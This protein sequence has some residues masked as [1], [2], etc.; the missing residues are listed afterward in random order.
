MRS[1]R[2]LAMALAIVVVATP[3]FA[4]RARG[5][6]GGGGRSGAVG[7]AVPRGS[8]RSAAGPSRGPYRDYGYR[9]SRGYRGYGPVVRYNSY[10]GYPYGFYGSGL[11]GGF[12]FGSPYAYPSYWGYR[13]SP[14]WGAGYAY[15]GYSAVGPRRGYGGIRIDLPER[16][17]EVFVDGY[18]SGT[19][20][21]FDGAR[22]ELT[23]EP[24]PHRIEIELEGFE[25]VSFDVNVEPGRIVNYR[26]Q[27]RPLNR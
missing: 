6:D 16:D 13:Y 23:L 2:I 10:Y 14:Y 8:V 25:P 17:A 4:Q 1:S 20:D 22:Q 24:G 3:S 15:P 5:R 26:S 9:G 19:V 7:R 11:Y 27:L 18:Y 21:D 12:Y